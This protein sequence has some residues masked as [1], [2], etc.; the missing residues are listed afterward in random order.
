MSAICKPLYSQYNGNIRRC[1]DDFLFPHVGNH[2]AEGHH[3]IRAHKSSWFQP[4]NAGF[5]EAKSKCFHGNAERNLQNPLLQRRGCSSIHSG[6]IKKLIHSLRMN[7]FFYLSFIL[8]N[9]NKYR[10]V[11]R[12]RKPSAPEFLEWNSVTKSFSCLAC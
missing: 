4:W 12:T 1:A 5:F 8:P 10:S 2:E 6:Q 3:D 7:E 9:H 11:C